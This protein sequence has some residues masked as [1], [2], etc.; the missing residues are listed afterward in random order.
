MPFCPEC[1]YEYEEGIEMC[2]DCEVKLVDHLS[3][4]HFDGDIIEVFSSFSGPEAG[5]V[6]EMLYNE[7]IFS[8]VSNELG[9]SI[10]GSVPSDAGEVK[11]YVSDFDEEKARELIGAY[12]EDNPL[13]EPDEYMVCNH[14]GARVEEGAEKCPYCGETLED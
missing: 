14:C 3:E 5:M 8:A 2:S 12:M 4:E 13:D 10:F 1:G 6:K 11:V 9:A 7:G